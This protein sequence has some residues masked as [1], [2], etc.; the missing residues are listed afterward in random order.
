MATPTNLSEYYAGQGQAL[1]TVQARQS[2]AAK[3]GITGY[4]GTG[5]Q[6]VTL[7]AYLQ[8]AGNQA[9]G[10]PGIPSSGA[11]TIPSVVATGNTQPIT[12]PNQPAPS[13]PADVYSSASAYL[14]TQP[15]TG[16]AG[17]DQTLAAMESRPGEI[18]KQYDIEN[19]RK[20]AL[21][22]ENEVNA[23]NE[24]YRLLEERART[25]PGS[26]LEQS[27]QTINELE[28]KRAFQSGSLAITAAYRTGDYQG[29]LSLMNQQASLELEPLKMRYDFFKDLY[30][31]T[32]DQKF[33]VAMKASDRAYQEARDDKS[34]LNDF[35]LQAFKDGKI[36][37]SQMGSI[38]SWD[39]LSN[40]TGAT[41]EDALMNQIATDSVKNVD[42][43]LKYSLGK[44]YAVGATFLDRGVRNPFMKDK[45]RTFIADT[46]AIL[47]N[48]TIDKLLQAK[49]SGATFGALSEGEMRLLAAAASPLNNPS[50]QIKDNKGNTIGYKVSE[51]KFNE[52]M[53]NI[54]TYA[55]IDYE[56]RTG[57][58]W[59]PTASDYSSMQDE[60]LININNGAL[61]PTT[62]YYGN[63]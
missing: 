35:K 46:E 20:V 50:L 10:T 40:L 4:T 25:Q 1:P 53:S 21:A 52:I 30:N 17:L 47:G 29:A 45:T 28:R 6:N 16:V 44:D 2:T 49:A 19:K 57:N 56:K 5:D 12:L 39:D 58:K 13:A 7:L 32:E 26:T 24:Q 23:L 36:D 15:K 27:Q 62:Q 41:K 61:V 55:I 8:G 60:D 18:A 14:S 42:N 48:L 9:Q 22:A 11:V 43:L 37:I 31:R 34:L 38:N 59:I 63:I 33:Q 3:A 54:K 51:Q